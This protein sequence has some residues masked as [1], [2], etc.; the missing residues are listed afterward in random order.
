MSDQHG[1]KARQVATF[2]LAFRMCTAAQYSSADVASACSP[3]ALYTPEEMYWQHM[4]GEIPKGALRAA[5]SDHDVH[6]HG[7]PRHTRRDSGK[8][9]GRDSGMDGWRGIFDLNQTLSPTTEP[10]RH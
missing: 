3:T 2:A 9:S 8:D 1:A 5:Y 6:A 4:Q 10:L 7:Y